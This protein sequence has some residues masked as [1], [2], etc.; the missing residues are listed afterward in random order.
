MAKQSGL[1]WTTLSI[2]TSAG[3]PTD[4]RNDV[5]SLDVATPRAV[6]EITGIDK[7]A[8]ER[9]LLLADGSVSI[10]GVFNATG[11]HLVFRTIPSTS[12]LR[13]TSIGV[14]G[15]SLAMEMLYTDYSLARS[16]KGELTYKT[17][18][19]LADGTVPTWA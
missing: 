19:S 4:V 9:L 3:S 16:D 2:D 8:M 1:G 14:G 10:T 12:V 6:Q 18:G 15:V 7:S 13:T 17:A 5:T 11:A